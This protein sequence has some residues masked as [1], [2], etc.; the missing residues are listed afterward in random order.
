MEVN[1]LALLLHQNHYRLHQT[2]M[3]HCYLLPNEPY[4]VSLSFIALMMP[5]PVLPYRVVM[6]AFSCCFNSASMLDWFQG[7]TT[8]VMAQFTDSSA[9]YNTNCNKNY[10]L[11]I[12]P[13]SCKDELNLELALGDIYVKFVTKCNRHICLINLPLKN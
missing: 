8:K 9:K 1:R 11:L 2:T 6:F 7:K 4:K 10:E 5:K 13:S 3:H 12:I